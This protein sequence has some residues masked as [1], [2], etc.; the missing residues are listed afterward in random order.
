MF[1]SFIAGGLEFAANVRFVPYVPARTMGRP[2]D[3]YPAEGGELEFDALEVDGKD[4]LFL[5]ASH[6]SDF[7]NEAAYEAAEEYAK[8][9]EDEASIAAYESRMDAWELC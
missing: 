6:W 4:A 9:M 1:I 7:I 3:C 5:L 2:E 8:E